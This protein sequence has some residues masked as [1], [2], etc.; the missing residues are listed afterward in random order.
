MKMLSLA[1]TSVLIVEDNYVVAD[2]LRYLIEGY[3]GS[4]A[5]IVPSVE[6]AFEV[7]A[8]GAIDVAVLDIDLHGKSVVP[9]AMD[10]QARGVPF[11][12]LT[13]Y[14]DEELLPEDLRGRPRFDKPVEG[15]R[16]VR[17]LLELLG[18]RRSLD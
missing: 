6:R 18:R 12:F 1:G 2:A 8:G 13:G 10:L 16:L 5:A 9:L 7:L 3:E 15:E 11:V 17:A 14:A 4:V